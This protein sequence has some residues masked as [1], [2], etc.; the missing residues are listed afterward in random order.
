MRYFYI[1]SS[2]IKFAYSFTYTD[3]R[4]VSDKTM[5]NLLALNSNDALKS[6]TATESDSYEREGKDQE[7]DYYH[8]FALD[9]NSGAKLRWRKGK[10]MIS[11]DKISCAEVKRIK[12]KV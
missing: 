8:N 6:L 9:L 7:E 12:A 11:V 4:L 2:K 10:K 5:A 1:I 3:L